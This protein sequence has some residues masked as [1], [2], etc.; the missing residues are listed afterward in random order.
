[1]AAVVRAHRGV[2]ACCAGLFA[3]C[4]AWAAGGHHAVDDAAI[5]EPGNC[6]IESWLTDAQDGEHLLHAGT[7]CRVGP[8][9]INGSAERSGRDGS[10]DAA[11]VLQGKWATKVLPQLS[12]GVSFWG[13]WQAHAAPHYQ[14]S[15]LVG[16]LSWYPSKDLAAHLNLGRDFNREGADR[17]RSGVSLE[18]TLP[19]GWTVVGERFVQEG[20]HF[21]RAGVRWPVADGWN[22]DLSRA[23][24]LHGPGASNWT[25]GASWQ[26]ARP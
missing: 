3:A 18:W 14:G 26:F 21:A 15:T 12:A 16:L 9:E 6:K 5:M 11:Y 10:S 8:L 22:V 24:R 2:V 13:N 4:S 25:L 1:M 17:Q 7:G 20:G 23:Q 19:V